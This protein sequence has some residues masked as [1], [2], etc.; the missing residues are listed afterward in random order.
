MTTRRDFIALLGGAAAWPLAARAQQRRA[1]PT[2]GFLGSATP[3]LWADR[4][5]AFH[6]GLNE[7]GYAE[8]HNV[9][10]EY[11]WAEDQ[12][13]RFASLA[14]QLVRSGVD[15]IAGCSFAATLAAKAATPTI[16]IV[17]AFAGDPVHAGLVAGLSRPGANITGA[18]NLN[19]E[20]LPKR[21][22][23]LRE[24][25]PTATT[26]ALL[27]NPTIELQAQN[28][29]TSAQAAARAVGLLAHVV[30][31][32]AADDLEAAFATLARLRVGGLVIAS[33]PLFTGRREQ[34]GALTAL[35]KVPAIYQ[36]RE[37]AAAGGLMS[38][39]GRLTEMYRLNGLYTARILK[40]ERPADLPVQQA[41]KVE[42]IINL[43][44][45]NTLGLTIPLPLLGRADEVIE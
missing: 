15:V 5:H 2:V 28:Q 14:D 21:L 38:Y 13:A 9:R 8:G 37:F 32:S 7:G 19:S 41:T 12:N 17:F 35:H 42:L 10:I 22:E 44:S 20:I 31:A 45:A 11:R 43:K 39:G 3:Q 29:S 4:L 1:M 36:Y 34:L 16:P 25:V 33:D 30:H 26:V 23:L 6:Q 40:G 18:T 24:M 27:L